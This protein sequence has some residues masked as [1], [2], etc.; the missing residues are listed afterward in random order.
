MSRTRAWVAAVGA[1]LSAVLMVL[2]FGLAAMIRQYRE[3]TVPLVLLL[4]LAALV[5]G[6]IALRAF[7]TRE[8]PPRQPPS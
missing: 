4:G 3:F 8:P 1:A 2:S 5:L 6:V 7:M